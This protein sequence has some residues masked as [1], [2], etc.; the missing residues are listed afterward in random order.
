M[1]F[2]KTPTLLL[3]FTTGIAQA[4]LLREAMA[5]LGIATAWGLVTKA[6]G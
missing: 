2:V 1:A 3:G 6:S 5:A 4:L